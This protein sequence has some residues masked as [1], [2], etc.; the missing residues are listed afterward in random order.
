MQSDNMTNEKLKEQGFTL[1][2]I[3][4]A[5]GI[6]AFGL[7][8]MASMQVMAIKTNG[9][10]NRITEASTFNMDIMEKLRTDT[11]ST[12]SEFSSWSP[13][14]NDP[15]GLYQYKVKNVMDQGLSPANYKTF[16][17]EIKSSNSNVLNDKTI[18]FTGISTSGI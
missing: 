6:L 5:M 8:A 2:E 10:A 4:I 12:I 9:K 16:D 3:I 14:P 13:L 1:I 7:L 15:S 18:V 11:I 17:V